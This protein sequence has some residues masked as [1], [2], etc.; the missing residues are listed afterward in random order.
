MISHQCS[1]CNEQVRNDAIFC[2]ICE[3]CVHPKC[4]RL[5]SADLKKLNQT[6]NADIWSCYKCNCTLFPFNAEEDTE[7]CSSLPSLPNIK[8][9]LLPTQS[10]QHENTEILDCKYYDSLS[11]NTKLSSLSNKPLC[12]FFH[13]NINS[14]NLHVDELESFMNCLNLKFDIIG[15]SETRIL[16][17]LNNH[18]SLPGYQTFFT[19]TEASHGGTAIFI[20]DNLNSHRRPDLESIMYSPKV[21]ESTF[22]EINRNNKPNIVVGSIYKHHALSA[23]EFSNIF[24]LPLLEK[25]NRQRKLLVLI[26]DFNVNLLNSNDKCIS[27]FLDILENYC[28]LPYITLPTRITDSS[29]TLIDNIFMSPHS[30]KYFSGNFVTGISDHLAQFAILEDSLDNSSKPSKTYK[31]WKNFDSTNFKS[32]F[33]ST[34]WSSLLKIDSNNPNISFDLFYNELTSLI[35]QYTPTRHLSKKQ[36]L[37]IDK[38]WITKGLRKSIA[39]RDKILKKFINSKVETT[40][41]RLHIKYKRYRN[42]IINLIKISKRNYYKAFFNNN[43]NNTKLVWKG[44]NELIFKN[45][46]KVSNVSLKLNNALITDE[47]KVA[48]AFNEYFTSIAQNLQEKIPEYG[49]FEEFVQGIS[50]NDSFFFKAVTKS[51]MLKVLTSL[52]FSKSNGDFSIPKQ[53]F[54]LIPEK[55]AG[56]LTSLI[57][58]AFE[59]GVFPTSL[60]IVKVVPI[61]KNK[62]SNLDVNNFRPISLL[63]NIDKIFEKLVHKRLTSFLLKHNLLFNKQ[64]GFR[65]SHST[66]QALITLT[67]S[68]RKSLDN[69]DFSCGVFIDLQKA[70]DTVDHNILL[71]K[72]ELYGIRGKCNNWFRSYLKGRKQYVFLN[73]KK[74]NYKEVLF[75]VP[76]G[77]VLGP[78]LFLIYINDLPKALI[79]SDVTLFA[80]DTC[81]L[82]SNSSL[83]QIEKRLNIELKLFL[84]LSF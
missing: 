65:K 6:G 50:P 73:G 23:F 33:L 56:I 47:S 40:K 17:K 36:L 14:L 41:S 21:L 45:K 30:Y 29:Q 19:P 26:G 34:D 35:N 84:N 1:L 59:T 75:G 71:R 5:N 22:V 76:Q 63:S 83:K 42:S 69:G 39:I 37:K 18:P 16:S 48:E 58:Q 70:F 55:L 27:D 68:I 15:L 11:F 60:K 49:N 61:F 9:S 74:S 2:N 54:S 82:Y 10:W 46:T 8:H 20:S 72:L 78:L 51:E 12:S 64:F 43:I 53:I 80:D 79:F 77:S 31:D 67:E 38:P 7:D 3:L 28:L 4:N 66:N 57:N 24:L 81:L 13:L 62:G 52:N 25:T 44:I 32:A